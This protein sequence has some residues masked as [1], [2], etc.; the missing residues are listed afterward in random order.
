MRGGGHVAEFDGRGGVR[1]RANFAIFP[2]VMCHVSGAG[3][4][5]AGAGLT[6]R[7]EKAFLIRSVECV[8]VLR[9]SQCPCVCVCCV[10]V[11]VIGGSCLCAAAAEL[12]ELRV[13]LATLAPTG[14]AHRADSHIGF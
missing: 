2:F 6:G 3:G 4:A 12:R 7:K 8:R 13:H 5:L 14:Y 1:R 10:S 9:D 11:R